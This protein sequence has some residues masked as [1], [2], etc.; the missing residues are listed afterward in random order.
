M[1]KALSFIMAIVLTIAMLPIATNTI[2]ADAA[3]TSGTTDLLEFGNYLIEAGSASNWYDTVLADNGETGSENDPIIIDSAEEFVCLTKGVLTDTAGKYYK[4]ADGIS[5]FDLSRGN[6]NFDGTLDENISAIMTS[7][8]NHAGTSPGFQGNFDGSG[9]T[10][11][12]A[13]SNHNTGNIAQYAGLFAITRG[14]VTIKNINVR[15]SS[16][17]ATTAAGGIVGYHIGDGTNTL[18]VE[19]CSVSDC[20]IEILN[21]DYGCGTGGI[22]GLSKNLS[23]F[24][25]VNDTDDDG[26]TTET[27]YINGKLNIKNCF[28]NLDEKYFISP[29]EQDNQT[30]TTLRGIH[31]GV[32]GFINTNA[33]QVSDCIVIGITPYA[34]T[35]C[36]TYNDIQHSG[37]EYHFTNVYT[38]QPSGKINI[39]G[40]LGERDFTDRV[41][42]LDATQMKG[43]AAVENMNLDWNVWMADS[44]GY[45][46]L[47]STHKNISYV[48]NNDQ[49]HSETCICG[50]GGTKS[51]CT[52]ENGKCKVCELELGCSKKQTIYWDGT[53]ATGFIDRSAGTKDDPVIINTAAELAYL[54]TSKENVSTLADGTPKYFKI[55]DGIGY[56]V[57]QDSYYANDILSL[58][59][60]EKVKSYFENNGWLLNSW[61]NKGWEQSAFCGH[62]DGNGA[63]IYGLYQ[64]STNNAGLFSS[65]DAGASIHNIAVLNS[66]FNT[67][68][69]NYQIG[70]I[71]A[72]TNSSGYGVKSNGLVWINGCIV[73]NCYMR[74]SAASNQAAR[75]GVLFGCANQD[76]LVVD[77]CLVY[78]NDAYYGESYQYKIPLIGDTANSIKAP[79]RK[80]DELDAKIQENVENTGSSMY[81]SLV[82]NTVV[83]GSN[84][85]NTRVG[86]GFRK[87]E[88]DCFKNCYTDGIT[89][90]VEFTNGSWT[91]NDDQI[92]SVTA[93]GLKGVTIGDAWIAT[94]SLPTLRAF[95]YLSAT[96]NA[97]GTHTLFCDCG[98]NNVLEPHIQGEPKQENII[99]PTCSA[100]G[101]YDLV[102]RCTA[103]YVEVLR[104]TLPINALGHTYDDD[105]DTDCNV[106]SETRTAIT[107]GDANNDTV[108]NNKDCVI[109]MRYINDWDVDIIV[110]ACDVNRDSKIN[111]KDYSLL[112]QYVT[113]WDICFHKYT[114]ATCTSPKT[115]VKCGITSG[116]ELG[117]NYVMGECSRINKGVLCQEYDPDYCP[118]LYFTGDMSQITRE[119]QT[120]KKIECDIDVQYRSKEQIVNRSAKIKIQGTSSTQWRKKNYTITLYEEGNF[121]QKQGIDVGWGQQSK[122]CLKANWIDKTHSRNVVSAKLVGEVQKKYNL[123]TN[124]PNNGAIDGFPVEVYIN[125]EF[126]GLYTMNI[127]KDEWQFGMDSDNP[128][129]IVLCGENWNDPVLF[130]DEPNLTDWSVEVGPESDE[131]LAKFARLSNFI[132]NSSDAEFK[133]NIHQYL[134]LDATLNYYVLM[135]YAYMMDNRGKNMLMV[136]YDGMVWYPSLY[137]L[138]TTWGT[139]WRGDG[140][141]SYQSH[142]TS[143]I[144]QSLLWERISTL[145]S[146]ELANRYFELRY[147]TLDPEYVMSKFYDF[148]NSIP[149]EVLDRE[150]EK[151]TRPDDPIPG[152]DISQIQK[153][154]DTVIYRL[155]NKYLNW[156]Y[157]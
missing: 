22:I 6:L 4:V 39:G 78:G 48:K 36:T 65:I 96:D 145:Y 8:K 33:M 125:G 113:G 9:V 18:T 100:N 85:V 74:S 23:S 60:T 101:S 104:K 62:F 26:D 21:S 93:D 129:H 68:A 55:A 76:S 37:L 56:I 97:D 108:I 88:P 28:V 13:W 24:K 45:P 3:C 67:S 71:A 155:D 59:S 52:Y 122:Y 141:Y 132:R 15:L 135:D 137:D 149:Q 79:G 63:K 1:K 146:K 89:G 131:T 31:G 38:D 81:Y 95:H 142:M 120:S 19:N 106:C 29:F 61:P 17:T 116:N 82:Y 98:I 112:V 148:H 40:T 25:D 69:T 7:G 138:D 152:Y 103:C 44:K 87:N 57:L 130:R 94:D 105:L 133:E 75:S 136:T 10:V 66:Y 109:L 126:H 117:H 123:L 128:N 72:V 156:K 114:A 90:K 51:D 54:I 154:L 84:I 151:W 5:A 107:F 157:N 64:Q 147:N 47:R 73:G 46:E 140:E 124:A 153:Y 121:D 20:H 86:Y 49:T 83:L 110:A 119:D 14:D 11:Y 43:A 139:N 150:T 12:G 102:Y 41:F 118:K 2:V 77:N 27:I 32:A 91:Y 53:I 80:P 127:P 50:F 30:D 99:N 34:T 134:N 42:E 111:N 35:S 144:N 92:K 16:F 70:A 115:C 143:S 58:D